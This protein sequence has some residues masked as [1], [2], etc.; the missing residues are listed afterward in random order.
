MVP[1]FELFAVGYCADYEANLREEDPD[2]IWASAELFNLS[3]F[4]IICIISVYACI[5]FCCEP[6]AIL[7]RFW[8]VWVKYWFPILKFYNFELVYELF[9]LLYCWEVDWLVCVL[10][11]EFCIFYDLLLDA[12]GIIIWLN[13]PCKKSNW[14]RRTDED[15]KCAN[16]LTCDPCKP[17]SKLF[18]SSELL[19][20]SNCYL[21]IEFIWFRAF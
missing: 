12:D 2:S 1:K 19:C 13:P 6:G 8:L 5:M 20:L 3:L 11:F 15:I 18:S 14:L 16:K 17:T 4:L 10:L 7:V 9:F 21:S